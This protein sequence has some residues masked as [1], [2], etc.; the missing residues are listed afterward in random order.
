MFR[1]PGH[2][3]R[4]KA[5]ADTLCQKCLKRGHYSYECKA[6][7]QERPYKS[8]PS[9]TQQLL[10]P[11]LQPKLNTH[12]PDDLLP[13]KGLA[14]QILA[15]KEKERARSTS[16]RK[17]SRPRS[18]SSYSDSVSTISTNRSPSRSPPPRKR[19]EHDKASAGGDD[20]PR[21][22]GRRSPSSAS[23]VSLDRAERNT[24]RRM[25]S[26]SPEERGR[27]RTRS[28]SRSRSSHMEVS[29][30][31]RPWP[32]ARRDRSHS[33]TRHSYSRRGARMHASPRSSPRN[34]NGMD[35]SDDWIPP[36]AHRRSPR[37]GQ[38]WGRPE[39][40]S[41][42]PYRRQSRSPSP[43]AKR[44]APR[45]PSPSHDRNP[46]G[47]RSSGTRYQDQ[48]PRDGRGA[49]PPLPPAPPRER[50]LSPFSK[51]VALTR[52]LQAGR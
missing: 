32:K 16:A 26:F 7:A 29:D 10:N 14:D 51:R 9:R 22:R 21:K 28:R 6:S 43:Y 38:T 44:R 12:V 36:P 35:T 20:A 17:R 39:S 25:S 37:P 3:G 31:D 40:R 2:G 45:S 24:R 1:R 46:G 34:A 48:A 13:K 42:S 18:V 47:Y 50:S 27:R 5:T 11:Q 41:R 8:R 15:S 4:S 52:Q 30:D 33:R 49:P 23:D 19:I